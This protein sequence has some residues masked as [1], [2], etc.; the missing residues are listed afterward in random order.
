MLRAAV[1]FALL[2]SVLGDEEY[3]TM[4]NSPFV[5]LRVLPQR[6]QSITIEGQTV[7]QGSLSSPCKVGISCW[8]PLTDK[9]FAPLTIREDNGTG[10]IILFPAAGNALPTAVIVKNIGQHSQVPP[11]PTAVGK[12][13]N[14]DINTTAEREV[15]LL[16]S[17]EIKDTI[18]GGSIRKETDAGPPDER[19]VLHIPYLEETVKGQVFV[20]Q[21]GH[22]DNATLEYTYKLNA[23]TSDLV[24][25]LP[26]EERYTPRVFR[27]SLSGESPLRLCKMLIVAYSIIS[28]LV[29]V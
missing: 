1:L 25:M 10:L 21:T 27:V 29:I 4:K 6:P 3:R 26:N 24:R 8:Q 22:M 12:I 20:L 19:H 14:L 16:Y 7:P 5:Y 13:V 23:S 28:C 11:L 17:E 9:Q 2:T 18:V 15:I